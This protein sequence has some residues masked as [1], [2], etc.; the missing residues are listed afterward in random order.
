MFDLDPL[1]AI[2]LLFQ[3]ELITMIFYFLFLLLLFLLD[4]TDP[5][6]MFY[7]ALHFLLLHSALAFPL[8]FP[9][10]ELLHLC[11]M[12]QFIGHDIDVGGEKFEV[13]G[14]GI[15][16]LFGGSVDSF[17]NLLGERQLKKLF[18]VTLWFIH[19][20]IPLPLAL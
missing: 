4:S 10:T 3:S 8:R 2:G 9:L 16:L 12:S 5:L 7:Q 20:S 15:G 11:E 18:I 17:E 13:D 1:K 14:C 6:K 19:I